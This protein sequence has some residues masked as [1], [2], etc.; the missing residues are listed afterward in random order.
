MSY[1]AET[2]ATDTSNIVCDVNPAI[3]LHMLNGTSAEISIPVRYMVDG[4]L[5]PIDL[6]AEG[7]ADPVF[8]IDE[9]LDGFSWI[10][11]INP[12]VNS[13]LSL[14]LNAQCPA[15]IDKDVEVD[16]S[17]LITRTLHPLPQQ[18]DAVIR[19]KLLIVASP[20]PVVN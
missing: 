3:E 1:R 14:S 20:L 16:Y 11:V 6:V 2:P 4:A 15:A 8:A 10:A 5:E 19:G 12:A 13:L 17:L 9:E 7:Y 18:T